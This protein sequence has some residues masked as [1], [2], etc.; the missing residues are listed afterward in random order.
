MAGNRSVEELA[1][2][3]NE[4]LTGIFSDRARVGL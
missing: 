4:V 3:E 2:E 1:A